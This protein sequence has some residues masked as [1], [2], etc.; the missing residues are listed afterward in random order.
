MSTYMT[1]PKKFTEGSIFEFHWFLYKRTSSSSL[2]CF[3][4]KTIVI[5]A[6]LTSPFISYTLPLLDSISASQ[7]HINSFKNL[8]SHKR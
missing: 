8:K 5:H 1:K 3:G 7:K 4:V 6:L 2:Y